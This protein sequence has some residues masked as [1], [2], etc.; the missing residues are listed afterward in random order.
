MTCIYALVDEAQ[1]VR[2]VGKTG[3]HPRKR[4]YQHISCAKY[5]RRTHCHKWILSMLARGVKP[6][7]IILEQ[8]DDSLAASAERRW[9]AFY[10]STQTKLTNGTDGG[11]GCPGLRHS[12]AFKEHMRSLMSVMS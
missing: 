12:N 1:N 9:I 8:C 6:Q 3:I 2:Y 4:L 10:R 11:D 5:R 7:V